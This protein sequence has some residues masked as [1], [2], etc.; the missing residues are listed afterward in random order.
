MKQY[1]P[2]TPGQRNVSTVDY[3]AVLTSSESYKP[4]TKGRKRMQGRGGGRITTRHKGGGS[5]R[6]W[7]DVD[8]RYDKINIPARIMS[9]EYDPNRTAFI[10]LVLYRDGEY[11]YHLIPEGMHVGDEML[12]SKNQEPRTGARLPISLMPVGV[13][14]YNIETYPRSGARLVR[15]AGN[16][17]EVMAHDAGF[18]LIKLPSGTIR[19]MRGECWASVGQLS[20]SEHG[21]V[22]LG[23]AGR[24][25][26]RGIRPTVRGSAMNPVDHPYGGGEGRARRGTRRPKNKW[27]RGVRGVKTRKPKKYSAL[28]IL[29][30]R[31]KKKKR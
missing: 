29:Q 15:S 10:A 30:G 1:R 20:N 14:V 18:T 24:T 25:R 7:R 4:L 31:R 8:F 6:L 2:T 11:R 17:A 13:L 28:F 26:W 12:V 16:T 22:V 23:K 19:K 27:G 21:Q 3:R 5:K 9:I